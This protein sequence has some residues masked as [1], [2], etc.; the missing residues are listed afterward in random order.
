M[1]GFSQ[2]SIDS[3]RQLGACQ[4]DE[5]GKII[6][7]ITN[8]VIKPDDVVTIQ[9]DNKTYWFDIKT[10]IK[11]QGTINPITSRPLSPEVLKRIQDR[12]YRLEE[13][14]IIFAMEF[15]K[16]L[17]Q[18]NYCG[19]V[20]EGVRDVLRQGANPNVQFE[21]TEGNKQSVIEKTEGNKQSVFEN[22][23]YLEI[24][25]EKKAQCLVEVLLNGGAD[26]NLMVG[27]TPPLF[28]AIDSKQFVMAELMIGKGADINA[29][30]QKGYDML[31]FYLMICGQPDTAI[32]EFFI[33]H[34]L[35][36]TP[37]RYENIKDIKVVIRILKKYGYP[38]PAS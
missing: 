14:Q 28:R 18:N 30:T 11:K 23:T 26:P 10:L 38:I 20:L 24:A 4:R 25:L 5:K 13:L 22:K 34:G 16:V 6:D 15:W 17:N 8:A 37:E 33:K 1:S 9:E 19:F 12:K 32:I 21:K 36:I 27:Y 3:T 35:K 2:E 7:P 31:S 29:N